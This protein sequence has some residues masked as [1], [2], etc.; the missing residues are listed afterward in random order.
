MP[1]QRWEPPAGEGTWRG[2][3]PPPTGMPLLPTPARKAS[4]ASIPIFSIAKFIAIIA[5]RY[6][7]NLR[8]HH[9]NARIQAGTG[10][11]SDLGGTA[12]GASPLHDSEP[13]V[14]GL[15]VQHPEGTEDTA[16]PQV[17]S[18]KNKIIYGIK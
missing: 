7:G 13:S 17:S 16:R 4:T 11:D 8:P 18:R 14:A 3:R 12:I 6:A 2:G 9:G 15:G 5:R 1:L 10:P